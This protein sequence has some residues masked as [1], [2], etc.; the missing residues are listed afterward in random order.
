MRF[1]WQYL[2]HYKKEIAL[3]I[4]GTLG[5]V[6]VTLGLPTLLAEMIDK[7]ILPQNT[8]L[9]WRYA[10]WMLALSILGLLGRTLTTYMASRTVNDMTM[11]IRNDTYTKMQQLSHH[12]FQEFGVPSLTTR[13]T[14]DAFMILQFTEMM[15]R[16]GTA[17]P[18]M[19]LI[20]IFMIWKTSPSLGLFVLPVAPIIFL[21]V[22]LIARITLPI[23]ERQQRNLDKINRILRE[24]ITGLRVLR[25]FNREPFQHGRFQEVNAAYRKTTSQLFKLMAIT[26]AVFSLLLNIVIIVILW[27]GAGYIQQG[28]LQVGTLVAFIEYVFHALYSLTLFAN[29]FMMYPRAT[30]S[31]KRLQEVL[32]VPISVQNPDQPVTETQEIGSLE[33]RDVDFAYPDASEP[34]LRNISFKTRPGE[35][36]AFIGSTGSGKSTIVKL[37]PRFYDVT[38]GQILVDGV[39]VRD[40]DL[41]TLRSKI[42]FTPQKALLFTGDISENLRY[43]KFDATEADM[44]RATDI[45]QAREFIERLDTKYRTEIAEG[46][47]NLS[48]GQRQRLSIARSIIKGRE[49]YI[50]DDSFSA[51]DYKTDAAVRQSLREE[52]KDASTIIVA[53]R[54]GTIM[55]ADQIIVLDKG[56]IA[57]QGTHQEL[58]RTSD[59]YYEIASSQLSK[60]ELALE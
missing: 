15:L 43:G 49:I 42:G 54:V 4:L 60:E 34:V 48:G 56:E 36:T 24:S 57:A 46:G 50:F 18:L 9:L 17:A 11:Q 13:I 28:N 14:T 26:P 37:I 55:H 7:A 3:I 41:K 44:D 38:K 1:I 16:Q 39:D 23:S 31:A 59:I 12:E 5:F 32:D 35:T 21:F 47:T 20:S 27:F 19:I 45:S 8:S 2:R 51:L 10:A 52:T 40:Y 22:M 53:Q 58:L 33:F 25:A 6:A 30:V 29:I